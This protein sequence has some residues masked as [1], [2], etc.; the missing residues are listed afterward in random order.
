MIVG[1]S[2]CASDAGIVASDFCDVPTDTPLLVDNWQLLPA[3]NNG[4]QRRVFYFQFY[5]ILVA[6]RLGTGWTVGLKIKIHEIHQN[7]RN[8]ISLIGPIVSGTC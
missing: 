5:E 3:A 2:V 6:A 1:L 7:L 4:K 8:P